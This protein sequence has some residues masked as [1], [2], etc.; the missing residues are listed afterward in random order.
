M[1]DSKVTATA[2]DRRLAERLR[3]LRVERGWSL[4]DLARLSGVSRATLSRLETGAVSPTAH[5]LGR[6]GAAHGLSTSRLLAMAEVE[7]APLVRAADQATWR[8]PETGFER[9]AVSPPADGL[10]GEAIA[11]ALPAGA[12]IAYPSPPRPGLEHHLALLDG[13]LEVTVDG[14]THRLAPGDCLRFRLYGPSAYRAP[15]PEAA[16]YLLFLV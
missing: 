10:A 11:G 14:R 9:R 12:E 2:I 16:R 15:G 4:D 8:D 13:A 3:A 1:E 6:L 7:P 5:T